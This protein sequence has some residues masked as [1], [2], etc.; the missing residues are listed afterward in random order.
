MELHNCVCL[1]ILLHI[2]LLSHLNANNIAKFSQYNI[3][4]ISEYCDISNIEL[5]SLA[6]K[7][8]LINS[9]KSTINYKTI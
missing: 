9:S 4:I 8:T 7:F 2:I 6:I 5:L 1:Y 3:V